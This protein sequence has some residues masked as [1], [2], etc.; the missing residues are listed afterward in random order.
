[1]IHITFFFF[2][3]I[4]LAFLVPLPLKMNFR[5]SFFMSTKI[6]AGMN[7]NYIKTVY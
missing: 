1:M 5:V 6:L 4:V 7:R 3:K 2:Y